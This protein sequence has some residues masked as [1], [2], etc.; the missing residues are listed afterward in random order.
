[1]GPFRAFRLSSEG[2]GLSSRARQLKVLQVL[3]V[4]KSLPQRILQQP[5]SP[6]TATAGEN[7]IFILFIWKK[8]QG[9]KKKKHTTFFFPPQNHLFFKDEKSV[10]QP[11]FKVLDLIRGGTRSRFSQPRFSPPCSHT[12]RQRLQREAGGRP[13]VFFVRDA[14]QIYSGERLK[15]RPAMPRSVLG[16][17]RRKGPRAK[18]PA[19][20]EICSGTRGAGQ[21]ERQSCCQVWGVYRLPSRHLTPG[22]TP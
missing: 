19:I 21:E 17:K 11:T 2:A 18:R 16:E 14:E 5:P 20:Q 12:L 13:G 8:N 6:A 10:I 22:G 15:R 4:S 7:N 1:M 3:S 9:E